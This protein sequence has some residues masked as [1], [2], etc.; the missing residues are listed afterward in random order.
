M[1]GHGA[2][3]A[4]YSM[5]IGVGG[6]KG[7]FSGVKRWGREVGHS[8]PFSVEVKNDWI[9]TSI[10]LYVFAACKGITLNFYLFL[11]VLFCTMPNKCTIN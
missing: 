2:Q 3:P 6:G 5:G 4:S 8:A 11:F 7:V 1:T 10:L 9:H